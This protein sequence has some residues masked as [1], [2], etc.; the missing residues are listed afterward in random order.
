MKKNYHH[1]DLEP[2]FLNK[3]RKMSKSTQKNKS[4]NSVSQKIAK[5]ENETGCHRILKVGMDIRKAIQKGRQLKGYTQKQTALY[6][7]VKSSMINDYEMG[8]AI[9]SKRFL[10]RLQSLLGIRLTGKNIG[11]VIEKKH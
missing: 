5:L 3:S 1:Q 11:E 4:Q 9:P 6:M 2:I 8:K 7:N 10:F